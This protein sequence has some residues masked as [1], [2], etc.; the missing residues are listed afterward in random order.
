M[1]SDRIFSSPSRTSWQFSPQVQ[2][3][4][5]AAVPE[6]LSQLLYLA[7]WAGTLLVLSVHGSALFLNFNRLDPNDESAFVAA[8]RFLVSYEFARQGV[9][10]F[11]VMSGFLVGGAAIARLR[12]DKP[13]LLDY[14]IHRFARIYLVL[15]P[16]IVL[17]FVLDTTGRS[18]FPVEFGAYGVS[19]FEGHYDLRLMLADFVNLQ[20]IITKFY[21]T[22]GPL[23]SIA[24]EFWYYIFFPLL[25]LPF[26]RAY[27]PG[28]RKI[29]AAVIFAVCIAVTIRQI[30]FAFGFLIWGL[31]AALTLARR[32][33][34]RSP[35]RALV[36]T[37]TVIV[38]L[39]VIFTGAMMRDYPALLYIPDAI[40]A[41]AFANLILTMRFSTLQDWRVLDWSGHKRLADFSFTLYAIH[42]PTIVFLRAAA[43]QFL[44]LEWAQSTAGA[45][46]WEVLAVST[47]VTVAFAFA[48][49]RVTE[50]KVG[51][52]RRRLR[53]LVD[54]AESRLADQP[55]AGLM[56]APLARRAISRRVGLWKAGGRFEK[57]R[58]PG[59]AAPQSAQGR[60][61]YCEAGD[62]KIAAAGRG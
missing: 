49:S 53:Q 59:V 43:S 24:Y 40:T 47:G 19:Y 36:L 58:A 37:A 38:A 12:E 61:E 5:D 32:P 11:F 23:W 56:R 62:G 55:L 8:W 1:I 52:A 60:G 42:N 25:L 28:T 46:Q 33:L 31:G 20:G 26:G 17:T 22:N 57:P 15:I 39:R 6:Q 30:W 13:F 10:G 51:V 34:M 4:A 50:A 2:T 18:I 54:R 44:G 21:G 16:A 29:V 14:C 41:A 45:E 7:R 35:A 9:I 27:S 3:R 48:L